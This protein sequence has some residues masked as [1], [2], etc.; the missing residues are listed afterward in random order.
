MNCYIETASTSLE[1]IENCVR[2][3]E[4]GA[5]VNL[6]P[7]FLIRSDIADKDNAFPSFDF[8]NQLPPR[9]EQKG[10]ENIE[11]M[12]DFY[13]NYKDIS[14][15]WTIVKKGWTL[16]NSGNLDLAQKTF[17]KYRPQ[18]FDGEPKLNYVLFDFCSRICNPERHSIFEGMGDEA[19]TAKIDHP[20]T[21]TKFIDYISNEISYEH[22]D[23]YLNTFKDYFSCYSDFSQTLMYSQ[24]NIN[25]PADFKA[26]SANFSK[27]KQFYGN[28]F[29]NITSNLTTIACI[30]NINSGREYDQ[31]E[32]MDIKQ[33]KK[34]NKANKINPLKSNPAF[35]Q[36]E[37]CLKSDIRNAS[38][39][40]W[41]KYR[42]GIVE[43]KSGGTGKLNKLPYPEY[44]YLCN[45]ILIYTA[46][47]LKLDL[48]VTFNEPN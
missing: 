22:M 26:T 35:N 29:E 8:I 34:I 4:E 47:L 44:L 13:K 38:H 14:E 43:Y 7:D 41:I 18:N 10:F 3:N 17:S 46:S 15:L 20:E 42:S 24:N 45:E 12:L 27:T 16:T 9:D 33:Y 11:E 48:A 39:H 2:S 21:Y 30:N 5:I 28:A 36:I 6:S 32:K 19:S 23:R 31:F 1:C 40:A 25:I 37:Q